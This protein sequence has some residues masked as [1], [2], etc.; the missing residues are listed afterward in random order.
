MPR[1]KLQRFAEN[2]TLPNLFQPD[3]EELMNG[4]LLKGKWL[5]VYFKNQ[6]PIVIELGCGKGEYTVGMAETFPEKNYIGLDIKG[7]RMWVGCTAAIEKK[8]K[9]VAFV[10]RH[11]SG[12]EHIFDKNEVDEI[13]ITFPDPRLRDREAKKRLTSPEYMARYEKVLKPGGIIHLKTDND[14]LFEYTKQ[15]AQEHNF[16]VIE[17]SSDVYGEKIRGP[18]TELQTYYEKIWI[19]Q[20]LKI[21]YIAFVPFSAGNNQISGLSFFE[22]VW[23]ITRQ[24]PE[25]RVTTY[26]AIARFLGSTGSAR[27]VGWALNACHNVKPP[28]PAHRVVNRNGLLSGKYHFGGLEAMQQLLL[29]EGVE[30]IDDKVTD[31]QKLLWTPTA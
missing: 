6:R 29:S 3:Y 1:R 8:L 24:V 9:N 22:K 2:T 17:C 31:F 25:G 7:S 20:G 16:S 4:F 21:K 18:V 11:I 14:L 28:V 19:E 23:E 26:G 15:V 27:M 30:V 10:R 12:I 5:D 13:W